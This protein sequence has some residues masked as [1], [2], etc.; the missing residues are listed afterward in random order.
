MSADPQPSTQPTAAVAPSPPPKSYPL[1][2]LG[3]FLFLA[4]TYIWL[5]ARQ[6][7]GDAIK[8]A[9]WNRD[10]PTIATVNHPYP[11][12]WYWVW[13]KVGSGFV[14]TDFDSRMAWIE[15][16]NGLLGAGAATL[17]ASTLLAAGVRLGTAL[18]GA[19]FLGLTHAWFYHSTQS[20]EPIM[21]QFW[22]M[23]SYRCAV[24]IPTRGQAAVIGCAVAW[25]IA[26][27]AYQSYILGG[28]GLLW[29]V[30]QNRKHIL[31]WLAASAVVGTSLYVG[32]AV[33]SG[34]RNL[35]GVIEYITH[36]PD[37][38][39]WGF[40]RPSV[41]LQLPFGLANAITPPWP[42]NR[43]WPGLRMGWQGLSVDEKAITVLI[44]VLTLSLVASVLFLRVAP[45][46]RRLRLG[47]VA[48]F[49][50]GLFAPFYLL[51]Y[52]NKLWLLSLGAF[53]LAIPLVADSHRR[54]FPI[55]VGLLAL[56]V[57]RNSQQ[58]Y[59]QRTSFD[60]PLNRGAIALEK[61]VTERDFLI[62]DGWDASNIYNVRNPGRNLIRLI[63]A[64]VSSETLATRIAET[65]QKGG[66]VYIFGLMELTPERFELSDIA[67]RGKKGWYPVIQ[68]YK[69]KAR[70]V[71]QG[72][73]HGAIGDLYEIAE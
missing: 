58:S 63:Y 18:A 52:Y 24:A 32:A 56:M 73:E 66:K 43:N 57:L 25:A 47:L 51:P 22:M 26:V 60:N 49:V 2:L 19:L 16:L 65:R 50:C 59:F 69:P 1:V 30:S 34:A 71:W 67:K 12:V 35:R 13:W 70:L 41:L 61:T 28:L 44:V 54:G 64:P 7:D 3:L 40:I 48:I 10:R 27:G 4:F 33:G 36:K 68:G 8:N 21:A 37:G 38:E 62:C 29:I 31:P 14:G 23:L 42:A 55:L 15:A 11:G 53:G 46:Q 39:Y 5:H 72:S 45:A 17:A 20:T 6:Y 9:V